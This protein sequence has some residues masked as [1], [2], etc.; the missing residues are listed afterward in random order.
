MKRFIK[1]FY[2]IIISL[3]YKGVYLVI[4]YLPIFKF[5]QPV[6]GKEEKSKAVTR[7]CLDRWEA[8][9]PFLRETKGSVLDIGC[10]I[11]YFSFMASKGGCFSYGVEANDFNITC[12][13]A[14]KAETLVEN[15]VFMKE[16]VD[17]DFVRKMPSFDVILNLS[18]FHHWVKVYGD[19]QSIE[20]MKILA[21]KCRAMIF[22]TGQSNE[23]CTKW[24]QKL[25]FMGKYPDK[26]I[27]SFLYEVGFQDVKIIG[28]FP[29]GLTDVDRYLFLARKT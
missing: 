3:M 21:S 1:R 11:G 8:I 5:Y 23:T 22:E 12:C 17:M 4:S 20:M 7:A 25:F 29:T 16:K 2:G 13:H 14:I 27:Q 19:Q 28:T 24:H 15:C 9:A 18:V 26:W 6:F 10:N